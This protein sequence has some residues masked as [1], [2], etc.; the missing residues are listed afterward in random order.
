MAA[1]SASSVRTTK[2]I[3]WVGVNREMVNMV[4][5]TKKTD[6]VDGFNGVALNGKSR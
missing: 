4:I 6:K 2:K 5:F 1:G 3:E